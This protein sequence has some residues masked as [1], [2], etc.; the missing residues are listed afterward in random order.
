MALDWAACVLA[1]TKAVNRASA[2]VGV[3]FMGGSRMW[4]GPVSLA[5]AHTPL[6]GQCPRQNAQPLCTP[7][8]E[9]HLLGR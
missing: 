3:P 4:G 7:M 1:V 9:A 2:A 5:G 8:R 6:C